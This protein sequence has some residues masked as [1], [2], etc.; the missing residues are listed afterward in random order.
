MI[1]CVIFDLDGVIVSTDN[2]HYLAWKKVCD[3]EGI[4]FDETINNKLRGVSRMESLGII[5]CNSNKIFSI[6]EKQE[7]AAIKNELYI[8]SLDILSEKNILPGIVNLLNL[9]RKNGLQIAIGSSSRN[10][11]VILRKIGLFDLFDAISDGT[12][13]T[14]S[15]P[16]PEV[17]LTAAKMCN[18]DPS[19]CAVVEDAISGVIAAKA[20]G[21][22]L[23]AYGDAMKSNL[24]DYDLQQMYSVLKLG[25]IQ[26]V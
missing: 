17:F 22:M 5:L 18:V 2:L 6:L 16:D 1:K 21:M 7:L 4:Y 26:N 23:F 19:E 13:I 14:K 3:L 12:N 24:K 25:G 8:K 15:K 10:A 11:K 9:L 20:A